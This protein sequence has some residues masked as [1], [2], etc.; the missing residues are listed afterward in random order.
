MFIVL[1]LTKVSAFCSYKLETQEVHATLDEDGNSSLRRRLA[2][3]DQ[4]QQNSSQSDSHCR[5]KYTH[6]F[7]RGVTEVEFYGLKLTRNS[8]FPPRVVQRAI[9]LAKDIMDNR[10]VRLTVSSINNNEAAKYYT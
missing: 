6:V 10:K 7:K 5:L 9:T 8:S 3:T 2:L 1:F 4:S